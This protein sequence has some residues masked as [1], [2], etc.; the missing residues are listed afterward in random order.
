[1]TFYAAAD[2]QLGGIMKV[3]REW[4]IS[5]NT[6]WMKELYPYVKKSLDYCIETWDPK[7]EGRVTNHIIIPMTLS[8][9]DLM[10]CVPAFILGALTSIIEMSKAV[11]VPYEDY[12]TLLEE[13]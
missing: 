7:H 12:E 9:G 13:R 10:A 5:G 11:N 1:M 6:E 4:R 2:G 8:S 3:Y